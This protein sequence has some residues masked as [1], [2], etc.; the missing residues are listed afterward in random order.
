MTTILRIVTCILVAWA[1]VLATLEFT[2][3]QPVPTADGRVVYR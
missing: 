2:A 3:P 1:L